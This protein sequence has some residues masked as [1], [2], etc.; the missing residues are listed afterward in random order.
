MKEIREWLKVLFT[1]RKEIQ[2]FRMKRRLKNIL[3]M[4]EEEQQ[5]K[6]KK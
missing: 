1:P 2:Y 4:L 5:K 6:I 3:F